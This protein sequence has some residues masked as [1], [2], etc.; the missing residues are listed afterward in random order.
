MRRRLVLSYLVIVTLAVVAFSVPVGISLV[1]SLR[2]EQRDV[3]LREARTVAV[4]LATAAEA[5]AA[6]ARGARLALEDLRGALEEQTGGRVELL[7][8]DARP[9]LGRPV[10][11]S[12]D[13][14]FAAALDGDDRVRRL[15]VSVLG[16]PGLQ[17]TVPAVSPAGRIDGAVR[18]TFPD[19]PLQ[20]RI[21]GIV[22][23]V[24]AIGT[25]VLLVS[26]LVG[27]LLARSLTH[28]LRLL[29]GMAARMSEGDYGARVDP[30]AAGPAETRRLAETLNDG[31]RRTG[32]LIDA[33]RAFTADASHQL[34]TPL[35]A[36]RLSL[37]NLHARL[38]D[39]DDRAA[40]D[41]V[42]QEAGRMTRLVNDLLVLARAQGTSRRPAPLDVRAV[43]EGRVAAWAAAAEESDV[44]LVAMPS[45]ADG[46][47]ARRRPLA[48][49]VA[50]AAA[51][52]S[53][54][55]ASAV[56]TATPGHLEQALD[57]VLETALHA[58]SPGGSVRVAVRVAAA[59]VVVT[60]EDDGPGLT[61][62]QRE[63]AF[64]RFWSR[65]PG[66]SG[67]GLAIVRQLVEHDGGEVALE[68][69]AGGDG[70][71][72][73]D[74]PDRLADAHGLRV[75]LVLRRAAPA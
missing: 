64:D 26:G 7:D 41:R 70:R 73:P 16:E 40:V 68:D 13:A 21:A 18:L 54:A 44:A 3:G 32:M 17:V 48:S 20:Q 10:A 65:T 50:A 19:A 62:E 6:T 28:P 43:V 59:S 49:A 33:Q 24:V 12:G 15:D 47:D 36:L 23:V 61:A 14:D 57:N 67:L 8:A 58:A 39:P 4:L 51:S 35:T 63:R 53:A 25:V 66:G 56:V 46:P 5:D 2:D 30:A 1:A 29:D 55:S 75:R 71:D 34:R 60:V 45:E 27:S 72:G 31:A 42:L 38:P 11:G 37:D 9:A 69:A 74:D 52:P 22:G